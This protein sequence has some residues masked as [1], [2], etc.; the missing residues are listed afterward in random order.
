VHI[1]SSA[2]SHADGK[3]VLFLTIDR[4]SKFTHVEF[5]EHAGKM[6]GS[7]FLSNVVDAFPHK[8]HKVL[9]DNGIAFADLP[10]NR[11]GP[12]GRFLGPHIFHRVCLEHGIGHRLTKPYH[13]W[14]NGQP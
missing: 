2:P 3:I 12:T 5:H 11:E 14:T 7:A 4:V 13:P 8:I 6:A 10:K 9:T 1:D